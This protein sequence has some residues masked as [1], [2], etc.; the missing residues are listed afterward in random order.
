[1][2]DK[3]WPQA[4]EIVKKAHKDLVELGYEPKRNLNLDI[5]PQDRNP[6]DF[7]ARLWVKEKNEEKDNDKIR[8]SFVV[9]E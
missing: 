9:S 7:Y 1:M 3:T 8:L 2:K 6:D 5:K 4:I